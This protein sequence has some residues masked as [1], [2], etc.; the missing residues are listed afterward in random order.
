MNSECKYLLL[1]DGVSRAKAQV[2]RRLWGSDPRDYDLPY[3]RRHQPCYARRCGRRWRV[4]D[5]IITLFGW[6]VVFRNCGHKILEI[7]SNFI[8]LN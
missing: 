3:V 7:D 2:Q 5:F 1:H 8:Y 4:V 6:P